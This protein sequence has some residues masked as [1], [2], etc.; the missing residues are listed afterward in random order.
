MSKERNESGWWGVSKLEI[1][2]PI[3]NSSYI[4]CNGRNR[5]TLSIKLIPITKAHDVIGKEVL[6]DEEIKKNII[7][8]DAIDETPLHF[9]EFYNENKPKY[10]WGYTDNVNPDDSDNKFVKTPYLLSSRTTSETIYSERDSD[11]IRLIKFNIYCKERAGGTIKK[12][13]VKVTPTDG[14]AITSLNGPSMTGAGSIILNTLTTYEYVSSDIK[15]DHLPFQKADNACNNDGSEFRIVKLGLRSPGL[16][17]VSSEI[18]ENQKTDEDLRILNKWFFDNKREFPWIHRVAVLPE[19]A[20]SYY[21]WG[22]D[23]VPDEPD[24]FPENPNSPYNLGRGYSYCYVKIPAVFRRFQE[25]FFILIIRQKKSGSTGTSFP[26]RDMGVKF[27]LYDQ[28]GNKGDFKLK[29]GESI[30]TEENNEKTPGVKLL[31]TSI[32]KNDSAKA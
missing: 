6:S 29:M 32:L 30:Y 18:F 19:G 28:Y 10:F 23:H 31:Q 3:S 25:H 21:C 1:V 27:R 12:I 17:L 16:V 4:Y 11:A 22:F 14:D 24:D 7:L 5:I 26:P 13:A 9:N 15:L 20:Y 8:V 2:E